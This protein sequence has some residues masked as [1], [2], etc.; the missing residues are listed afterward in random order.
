MA[1]RSSDFFITFTA[2]PAWPEIADHLLHGQR[3]ADRPDLVAR[4]FRLKLQALRRDLT[5]AHVLGQAL[6]WTSLSSR[7]GACRMPASFSWSLADTSRGLLT[8]LMPACPPSPS[9]ERC[10]GSPR[11]RRAPMHVARTARSPQPGRAVHERRC[12][13]QGGLPQQLAL[14][15][16]HVA[17]HLPP[18]PLAGEWSYCRKS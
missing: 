13:L 16:H 18:I 10:S 8:T 3:A 6:A 17:R 14:F 2:N 1:G 7:S 15:D 12:D 5:V 4:V 9:S 11:G